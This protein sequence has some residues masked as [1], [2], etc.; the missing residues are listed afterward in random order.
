MPTIRITII[1][2]D[3]SRVDLL[4][5]DFTAWGTK[6]TVVSTP[7][8]KPRNVIAVISIVSFQKSETGYRHFI[9]HNGVDF[10]Q[11]STDRS[12]V[13]LLLFSRVT[14]AWRPR[15]SVKNRNAMFIED[16]TK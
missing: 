16:V 7:A 5:Q 6:A 3:T 12:M 1:A 2:S 4:R 14:L 8:T 9:I 15:L 11:V 10:S 13:N